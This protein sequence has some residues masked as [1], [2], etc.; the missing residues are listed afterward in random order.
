VLRSRIRDI[1][2]GYRVYRAEALRS[3]DLDSVTS[4]G[5][6]FQVELA[7]RL[8][9]SGKRVEEYPI[10]FI[11]RAA[12]RS[13]MHIGIVVEALYRVTAWGLFGLKSAGARQ[14]LSA[15]E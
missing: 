7:Y 9:R 5:Y 11:E 1:T 6:C 2:A 3:L 4:D 14:R 13:K 15:K 10:V 8:E 12:G